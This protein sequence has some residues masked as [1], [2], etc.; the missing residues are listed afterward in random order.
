MMKGL[1]NRCMAR[2]KLVDCLKKKAKAVEKG[3]GR[4]RDSG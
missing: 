2:E 3:L 1:M 4:V